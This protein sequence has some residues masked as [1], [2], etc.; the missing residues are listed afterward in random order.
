M[1]RGDYHRRGRENKG[2]AAQDFAGD[3][4]RR[5]AICPTGQP[6]A[7]WVPTQDPRGKLVIRVNF[8]SSTCKTCPHRLDCIDADGVRRT[9]TLRLPELQIALQTARQRENTTEFREHYGNRAGIEGTISQGVRAFDL[10]RS[11]YIRSAK[12]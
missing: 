9:L 11:C 4:K 3:W 6:I 10:R 7:N 2:F 5:K 12:T 8:A 1:T